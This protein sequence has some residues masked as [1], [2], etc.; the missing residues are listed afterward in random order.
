M[1]VE[2]NLCTFSKDHVARMPRCCGGHIFLSFFPPLSSMLLFAE[3]ISTENPSPLWSGRTRTS[4]D[5]ERSIAG[6]PHWC[7][8]TTPNITAG[9]PSSHTQGKK[10]PFKNI[11]CSKCSV[12]HKS[13]QTCCKSSS[14]ELFLRFNTRLKMW[15][16][17]FFNH[18]G[19]YPT[20]ESKFTQF[21][22]FSLKRKIIPLFFTHEI[23]YAGLSWG[24]FSGSRQ[25]PLIVNNEQVL[26]SGHFS[27]LLGNNLRRKAERKSSKLYV[28]SPTHRCVPGLL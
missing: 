7:L 5:H 1:E 13:T 14:V 19:C 24:V 4:I 3:R 23:H 25:L 2:G 10:T 18:S 16:K 17:V 15:N 9:C 21:A 12:K 22:T 26:E 6:L 28:F 27:D 20:V 11:V 8:T